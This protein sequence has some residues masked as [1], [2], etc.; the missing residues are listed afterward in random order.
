MERDGE[1]LTVDAYVRPSTVGDR[2]EGTLAS[3]RTLASEGMIDDLTVTDWPSTV[4]LSDE[5]HPEVAAVFEELDEWARRR[6]VSVR[7]PFE[8]RTL[9]SAYAEGAETVLR[10]PMLCVVV[11]VGDDVTAVFPHTHGDAHYTVADGVEALRRGTLVATRR[12]ASRE[13]DACPDC[14]G[15]LIN[16]QGI[17]ACSDCRW[18]DRS[19]P[20]ETTPETIRE[21]PVGE[22][23][24]PGEDAVRPV[25]LADRVRGTEN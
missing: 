22:P 8:V 10:T 16:V 21:P 3:L 17:A 20:R 12:I 4:S 19:E 9:T 5:R 18:S 24:R 2:V 25:D 11:S 1:P 7:P 15:D 14:G 13:R 6:G 23:R